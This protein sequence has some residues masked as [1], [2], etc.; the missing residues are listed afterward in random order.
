MTRSIR[1]GVLAVALIAAAAPLAAQHRSKRGRSTNES[2][3]SRLDTT[4]VVSAGVTVD[5]S[6]MSG[7]IKVTSWERPEVRIVATSEDGDLRFEASSRRVSLSLDDDYGDGGDTEY[8]VTVPKSARLIAGSISANISVRG[9]SEAELTSVSGNLVVSAIAG[10]TTLE[11]VSG[12]LQATDLGGDVRAQ[13]VSGDLEISGVAGELNAESVSG[14][15]KLKNVKSSY[16]RTETVSGD[17]EFEGAMDPK[18][19]YEFHSHSGSFSITLP[20]STGATI[21]YRGFSG[22]LS[23][24]C[25]MVM[26]RN[27]GASGLTYKS[28]TFTIGNG[29]ARITIETFS[30]DVE[31]KGC[32]NSKSKE[33]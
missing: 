7:E 21:S 23:S 15:L 11:T 2:H 30:G 10:R 17:L 12:E 16:V 14:D 19:R 28:N 13:T 24:S 6:L 3:R 32:S 5:L 33:D 22:D 8:E 31:I 26:G 27:T 4:V 25:E 18:G 1:S 9:V 20:R 29:G